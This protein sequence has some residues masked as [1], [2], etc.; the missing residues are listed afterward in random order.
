MFTERI[1]SFTVLFVVLAFVVLAF[2][3]GFNLAT[4]NLD[5]ASPVPAATAYSNGRQS[6]LE[7]IKQ[8]QDGIERMGDKGGRIWYEIPGDYVDY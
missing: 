5:C 8:Q 4:A 2:A 7:E 6:V 3:I 1:I